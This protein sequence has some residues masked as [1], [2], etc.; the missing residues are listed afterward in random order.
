LLCRDLVA[1][2]GTRAD[3]PDVGLRPETKH[4]LDVG[5]VDGRSGAN[6]N[7]VMQYDDGEVR[8]QFSIAFRAR[9]VGGDKRT[10]TESD[11]VEWLTP[12]QIESLD[13]HA[14]TRLRLE[15]ALHGDG[16]P[17]IG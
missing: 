2:N 10:S 4:P 8:Q 11:E 7:H 16:R 3:D 13:L 1:G 6:P 17:F 9:L 5:V 12:D 14:S 15:H